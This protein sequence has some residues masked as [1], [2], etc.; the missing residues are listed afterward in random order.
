[1]KQLIGIH[2]SESDFIQ[3]CIDREAWALKK[4]YEDY[5]PDM[6][7]VCLRYANNDADALD[8]LHDGFIKVFKNLDKYSV[9]TSLTSWIKRIMVNTSIDYYRRETR[10]RTADIDTVV[11][12]SDKSPDIL[13]QINS[14]EL[15]LSLQSLTPSYRSV[16]NLYVVEGYSH[17]EISGMLG[18]SESTSRSNLV[19]ARV[20]L[21][22]YLYANIK[23]IREAY[24]IN[25]GDNADG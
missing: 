22:E 15:L 13:S 11:G 24:T 7:P 10:R 16:F 19:K 1:M 9:G 5:Y 4:L 6:Y 3:S 23:Y 8:I 14:E 2:Y 17:K 20:K 21:R 18:I 12:I 25:K